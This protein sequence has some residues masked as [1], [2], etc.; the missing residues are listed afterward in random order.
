MGDGIPKGAYRCWEIAGRKKGMS[1]HEVGISFAPVGN[2]LE[3]GVSDSCLKGRDRQV[4]LTNVPQ[5]NALG[6]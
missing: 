3:S 5:R 6:N 4:S 1:Q 2:R